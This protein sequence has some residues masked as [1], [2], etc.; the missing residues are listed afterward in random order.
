M[1]KEEEEKEKKVQE[2]KK[3]AFR[4]AKLKEEREKL[5]KLK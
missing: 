2:K 5:Q 3:E 4:I 1:K